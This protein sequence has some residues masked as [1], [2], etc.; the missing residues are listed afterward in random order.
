MIPSRPRLSFP[1]GRVGLTSAVLPPERPVSYLRTHTCAYLTNT[2]KLILLVVVLFQ[3]FYLN[4][5]AQTAVR[6]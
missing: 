5:G 1:E 3:D 2:L 4:A 6:L